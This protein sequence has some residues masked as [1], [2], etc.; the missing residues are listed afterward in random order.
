LEQTYSVELALLANVS[1][2]HQ[3]TNALA[4][5]F[6]SKFTKSK[7]VYWSATT[8][9]R[10]TQSKMTQSKMTQS[11]MTQSKMTQS[12]MTQSKMTLNTMTQGMGHKAEC[13]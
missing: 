11:K 8:F 13:H 12:K 3:A 10:M 9:T 5:C 1:L 6:V 7:K 2:E 4:Y